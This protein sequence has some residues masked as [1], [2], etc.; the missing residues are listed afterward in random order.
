MRT[1]RSSTRAENFGTLLT[2]VLPIL[3]SK[4]LLDVSDIAHLQSTCR[5]SSNFLSSDEGDELW[6]IVALRKWP[7]VDS[8][9]TIGSDGGEGG[10]DDSNTNFT[11][12]RDLFVN[13][14]KAWL[15]ME[16]ARVKA[17]P[18]WSKARHIGKWGTLECGKCGCNCNGEECPGIDIE[19]AFRWE[20]RETLGYF[21]NR[22]SVPNGEGY[23][24][25]GGS[26]VALNRFCEPCFERMIELG[27]T[28]K[29]SILPNAF[30][31]REDYERVAGSNL[32]DATTK[33]V[34]NEEGT[35]PYPP[36][37]KYADCFHCDSYFTQGSEWSWQ[38]LHKVDSDDAA[39]VIANALIQPN[40]AHKHLNI[41]AM[42]FNDTVSEV[43]YKALAYAISI[44][45]SLKSITMIQD[46]CYSGGCVSEDQYDCPITRY[47]YSPESTPWKDSS[48][49]LFRKALQHNRST[50]LEN[51][52]LCYVAFGRYT[53]MNL[54]SFLKDSDAK[55]AAKRKRDE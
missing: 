28:P 42:H 54:D 47:H 2:E 8:I 32:F 24:M 34:V 20:R 37:A 25:S 1:T 33:Y 45:T 36:D 39:I 19:S 21:S 31:K 49:G 43:G 51:L 41:A 55:V 9:V 53:C 48:N 4:K 27:E 6:K 14:P 44:N 13:Y 16:A 52:R 11:S 46:E 50:N 17:L 5:A 7:Y 23:Q 15:T 30:V 35:D 40:C 26:M 18:Q 10:E 22:A 3:V 12:Y 29:H 38:G